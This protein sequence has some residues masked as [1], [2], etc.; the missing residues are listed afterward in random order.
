ME[1]FVS[2]SVFFM[3]L[4]FTTLSFSQDKKCEGPPDMCSQILDLQS[5]IKA[6]ESAKNT[7][8]EDDKT[9]KIIIEDKV[10][11]KV[12]KKNKNTSEK[13]VAISAVMAVILKLLISAI[14]SWT[15]FFKTD[16]GKA[17]L[18]SILITFGFAAFILT[19]LGL[20]IPWWQAII[21]AGGPPGAILV[22]ELSSLFP[23][24]LG[25]KKL[26]KPTETPETPET[27]EPK[28]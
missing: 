18:K 17:A 2:F 16:K 21:L 5:K 9:E 20:G 28:V 6:Y 8:T 24:I 15:G 11:D 23:V 3:L 12:E 4:S 13:L 19:N 14:K 26:P 22:N 10:E 1:K 25:K 7:H 27:P